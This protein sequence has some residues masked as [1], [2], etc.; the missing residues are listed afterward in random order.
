MTRSG[1]RSRI[2]SDT[3]RGFVACAFK[4]KL[5]KKSKRRQMQACAFILKIHAR[6]CDMWLRFWPQQ[7]FFFFFFL[8]IG[9]FARLNL[10]FNTLLS[11]V[12]TKD[13]IKVLIRY[14]NSTKEDQ[15]FA[16]PQPLFLFPFD[17]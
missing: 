13:C 7:L 14:P 9:L 15:V 2:I 17:Q 12:F 8:A 6:P 4:S 3:P 11:F 16:S 5:V 1:R 10:T